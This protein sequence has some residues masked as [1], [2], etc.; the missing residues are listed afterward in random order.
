MVDERVGVDRQVRIEEVD[1]VPVL[2]VLVEDRVDSPTD[3]RRDA[4][5]LARRHQADRGADRDRLQPQRLEDVRPVGPL[6]V[7]VEGVERLRR[8]VDVHR[9]LDVLHH[10]VVVLH[11]TVDA[12]ERVRVDHVELADV[13][14][15]RVLGALRRGDAAVAHARQE[16]AEPE[17]QPLRSC[18]HAREHDQKE[19][20]D[21]RRS[22]HDG[23][24]SK[25]APSGR[26][27][28]P[29]RCRLSATGAR[30]PD[31]C[32]CTTFSLRAD[33]GLSSPVDT[34]LEAS[35]PA[36]GCGQDVRRIRTIART[37]AMADQPAEA[38]ACGRSQRA[39]SR[40]RSQQARRRRGRSPA[41]SNE[42]W[43]RR[44]ESNRRIEVLQ[45]SALATWLR[46]HQRSTIRDFGGAVQ[47]AHRH[48]RQ[49]RSLWTSAALTPRRRLPPHSGSRATSVP[50]SLGARAVRTL[51]A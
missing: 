24:L 47:P 1:E 25:P 15:Q 11:A 20:G 22:P 18:L 21:E 23:L 41:C 27:S 2:L 8:A 42:E 33:L 31:H 28:L 38:P 13:L 29:F 49:S 17:V 36:R 5:A 3:V 10:D 43:R 45:T 40:L 30:V 12:V 50:A 4:H 44:P 51:G 48:S 6:V 32:N 16:P 14:E 34:W 35:I 7:A 46:R 37:V 19:C 26:P 39:C 9:Q